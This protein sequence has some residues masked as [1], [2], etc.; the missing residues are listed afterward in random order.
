MEAV[1]KSFDKNAIMANVMKNQVTG[2]RAQIAYLDNAHH[3]KKIA[4]GD[5]YGGKRKL[6]VEIQEC[7]G[8]LSQEEI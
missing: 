1:K 8:T 2:M 4:D 7:G 6:L 5:Y 3:L